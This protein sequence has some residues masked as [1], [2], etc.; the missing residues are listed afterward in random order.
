[1]VLYPQFESV[2]FE[3]IFLTFPVC[4]NNN[5]GSIREKARSIAMKVVMLS[6]ALSCMVFGSVF[7]EENSVSDAND[8]KASSQKYKKII[9]E[10]SSDKM[11][12]AQL[13]KALAAKEF[14]QTKI[15][16]MKGDAGNSLTAENYER[17][18]QD[19]IANPEDKAKK[20][21]LKKSQRDFSETWKKNRKTYEQDPRMKDAKNKMKASHE[22]IEGAEAEIREKNPEAKK[23]WKSEQD[24]KKQLRDS[25]KLAKEAERKEA[26]LAKEAAKKQK[27]LERKQ[28]KLD[29]EAAKKQK[30]SE[31]KEE[32]SVKKVQ[33]QKA[34]K[35]QK[36][37]KTEK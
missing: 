35:E 31:R 30:E 19:V 33:K 6:A 7:A 29:K 27:K 3:F 4:R 1:L 11:K 24:A 14:E 13:S 20:E 9:K 2:Y 16:I 23:L 32:K 22:A 28:A 34:D 8:K 12:Q 37:E 18:M 5:P 15:E 26:K 21:I 17:A 36:V 25:K 10:N